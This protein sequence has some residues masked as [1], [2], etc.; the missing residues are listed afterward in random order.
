MHGTLSKITW[1]VQPALMHI[2]H[3]LDLEQRSASV[4]MEHL[5]TCRGPIHDE[6]CRRRR[7]SL[8]GGRRHPVPF[9]R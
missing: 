5:S 9:P 2:A 1:L 4:R 8:P 6:T 3:V 7:T